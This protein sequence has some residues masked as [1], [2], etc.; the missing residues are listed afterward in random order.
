MLLIWRQ[1]IAGIRWREFFCFHRNVAERGRAAIETLPVRQ[2]HA[3]IEDLAGLELVLHRAP[4]PP[5]RSVA[6]GI[7]SGPALLHR[8]QRQMQVALRLPRGCGQHTGYGSISAL[9]GLEPKLAWCVGVLQR[10]DEL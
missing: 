3:L 8:E 2:G 9:Q 5:A 6:V 1:V 10:I 4:S 7:L